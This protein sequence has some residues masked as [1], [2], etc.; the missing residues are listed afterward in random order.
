MFNPSGAAIPRVCLF[1]TL[2]FQPRDFLPLSGPVSSYLLAVQ[3]SNMG[4]NNTA[5][6]RCSALGLL[7]NKCSEEEFWLLA[8]PL[9]PGWSHSDF[10]N[11]LWA[12]QKNKSPFKGSSMVMA[13]FP[14]QLKFTCSPLALFILLNFWEVAG[15]ARGW[16]TKHDTVF[17]AFLCQSFA[18]ML[19]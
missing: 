6:V 18:L 8:L 13:L 7:L 19:W 10:I 15:S 3:P 14:H 1:P 16:A 11:S 4:R 9:G 12:D 17:Y 2:S 5:F